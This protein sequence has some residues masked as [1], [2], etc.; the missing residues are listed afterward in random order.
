MAIQVTTTALPEVKIIEPKVFGDARGYFYESFNARE[1]AELV[2]PGVEFVQ[3][4]HSR[5]AKDVLRG[6]HYQIQHAQGK[7]VRVVEGEVFDVV[8]DLR[9]SSPNFG[10]WT[11][12]NLSADNY[13]QLWVP[14][15]FAHGFVVLSES[16]QF[17]YKTT[18]YWF[19]EHERSIVWNDPDIGIAWP[20]DGEPVV[21][22]KDA[23]GKRLI[24]AEVYA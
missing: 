17:L 3:D 15:G 22:A 7:L 13:R 6:L 12:V 18:D 1:F 23:A 20:I 19:P 5:S 21:A 14:P 8:V 2:A 10:R 9:R 16:A 4:N 11:G 24:D